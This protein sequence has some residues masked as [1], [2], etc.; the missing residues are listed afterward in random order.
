MSSEGTNW[1]HVAI[2]CAIVLG[3]LLR[4]GI[5]MANPPNNSFDDYLTPIGLYN[6]ELSRP[7]P[8][9]CW[10]CYQPPVYMAAAGLFARTVGSLGVRDPFIWKLIQLLGACFSFAAL[11][12][13]SRTLLLWFP[14][15]QLA[16]MLGVCF[17]AVLPRDLYTSAMLGN[18]VLLIFFVALAIWA[19]SRVVRLGEVRPLLWLGIGVVGACWTKQSGLVSLLLPLGLC[20]AVWRREDQRYGPKLRRWAVVCFVAACLLG[21]TDEAIRFGQTGKLLVSNQDYFAGAAGQPPGSVEATSFSSL[22]IGE[23]YRFPFMSR[24]TGDSFWTH[25]FA[26]AWFDFEPRF[27]GPGALTVNTGRAAITVGLLCSAL[28]AAGAVRSLWRLRRDPSPLPLYLLALAFLAVPLVQTLRLPYYSSMKLMFVLP[29][30]SVAAIWM[31]DA[32]D[33]IGSRRW[34]TI[35]VAALAL[36]MACFALFHI[37]VVAIEL[38][39][40]MKTISGPVW[41][42][43]RL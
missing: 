3:G 12:L 32:A 11:W 28:I 17:I 21:V 38:P 13:A 16:V 39:E 6:K 29:A 26:R 18:D 4:W 9:D 40:S 30:M 10:Q 2:I 27:L 14:R 31:A 34:G 7:H 43:P 25:L 36:V 35:A 1:R 15:S 22:R 5:W 23:L 20:W 42:F 19:Y 24:E 37:A 33:W 8:S 41:R